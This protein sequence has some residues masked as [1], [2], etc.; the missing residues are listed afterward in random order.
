MK[1]YIHVSLIAS[2]SHYSYVICLVQSI[3]YCLL[4]FTIFFHVQSVNL[5]GC[6]KH[7][8]EL[9]PKLRNR[10]RYNCKASFISRY[11]FIY[12]ALVVCG[13]SGANLLL[14]FCQTESLFLILR[15]KRIFSKNF[16]NCRACHYLCHIFSFF[17]GISCRLQFSL[18][19]RLI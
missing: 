10:E 11:I 6:L 12:H 2:S 19:I 18:Y 9:F 5:Y 3:Y 8:F 13:I 17:I 14:F 15:F 4:Y 7:F 1:L 16:Y